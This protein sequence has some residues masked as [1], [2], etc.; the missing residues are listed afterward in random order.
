[1]KIKLEISEL[2]A[3]CLQRM[4]A[5]EIFHQKW[6]YQDYLDEGFVFLSN[7]RKIIIDELLELADD[8][9]KQFIEKARKGADYGMESRS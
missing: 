9:E 1:M 4:I 3:R 7:T 5:E 8:L 6:Y 2:V